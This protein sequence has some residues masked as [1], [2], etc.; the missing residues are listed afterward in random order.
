MSQEQVVPARAGSFSIG[1][2]ISRTIKIFTQRP[3]LFCGFSLILILPDVLPLFAAESIVLL[4]VSMV[5]KFFFM[6]LIQGAMAYSVYQVVVKQPVSFGSA[7]KVGLSRIVP[8]L[9]VALLAALI[10]IVSMGVA[11]F[12]G[13]LLHMAL[14]GFLAAAAGCVVYCT[15]LVAVPACVVERI[16]GVAALSRS[17]QLTSGNRLK[18]AG[19]LFIWAVVMVL[20]MLVVGVVLGLLLPVGPALAIGVAL[21]MVVPSALFS[22]MVAVA[23]YELRAAKEGVALES[24]TAI[25]D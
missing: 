23:Y 14:G 1:S 16:G 19:L 24:L 21:I 2:A 5:L 9:V 7:A 13:S 12:A 17:A 20:V 11:G 15:I 25:F 10:L 3:L 22:V 18:I 4:S 8:L 6:L